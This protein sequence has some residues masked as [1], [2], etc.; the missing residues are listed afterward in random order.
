M[1]KAVCK[2]E[3]QLLDRERNPIR[4]AKMRLDYSGKSKQ[5]SSGN[6]GRL[7]SILTG[8][9]EDVVK[10]F[11]ARMDGTWKLVTEITSDWGNK[12]VTLVSPKVKIETKTMPHPRDANGKLKLDPGRV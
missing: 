9:P 8:S 7:P 12:L 4:N 10:I 2:V 1:A 5:L 3:V 11:I 6:N